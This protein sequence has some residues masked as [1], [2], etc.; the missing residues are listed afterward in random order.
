[1]EVWEKLE[2]PIERLKAQASGHVCAPA[3]TQKPKQPAKKARQP[4]AADSSDD[5]ASDDDDDDDD[6]RDEMSCNEDGEDEGEV[7]ESEDESEAEESEMWNVKRILG[8]RKKGGK[9]EYQVEWEGDEWDGQL[10]WE[11]VA[12]VANT[13]ALNEYLAAKKAPKKR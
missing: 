8:Q 6:Q 4:H 10:T 13:I 7:E 12:N 1:M 11:P 2:V 9:Q 5:E 3:A